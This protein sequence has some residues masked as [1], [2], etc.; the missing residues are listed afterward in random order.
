MASISQSQINGMTLEE[1]SK[2]LWMLTHA[3][4]GVREMEEG[5]EAVEGNA[6]ARMR[7]AAKTACEYWLMHERKANP[8]KDS[9]VECLF[10]RCA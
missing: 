7:Q 8:T 2:L 10:W 6:G 9:I 3:D 4:L 5:V 1:R